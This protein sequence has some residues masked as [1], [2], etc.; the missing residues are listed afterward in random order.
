ARRQ[1]RLVLGSVASLEEDCRDRRE[2]PFLRSIAQDTRFALRLLRR[3]PM[4][5]AV[6]VVTLA[7]GIGVTTA[8][9][10]LVDAVLLKSLPVRD[11]G[12]LVMLGDGSSQGVGTA[13]IGEPFSVFSFDLYRHL[14]ATNLFDGLCAVQSGN[15]QV[16]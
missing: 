11:P 2:F 10:S 7:I 8:I 9:F 16:V 6:A 4:F 12:S 14:R 13:A 15:S 3:S 5:A 1:A